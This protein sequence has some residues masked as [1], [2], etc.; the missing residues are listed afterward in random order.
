MDVKSSLQHQY[1]IIWHH[2]LRLMVTIWE[3]VF[4]THTQIVNFN[5]HQWAQILFKISCICVMHC[6]KTIHRMV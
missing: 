4:S 3:G 6:V 5:P 1:E 2:C